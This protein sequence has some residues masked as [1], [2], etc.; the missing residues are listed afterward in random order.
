LASRWWPAL[1]ERP[2]F[3]PALHAGRRGQA[4]AEALLR[5]LAS[6]PTQPAI[7]RATALTLLPGVMTDASRASIEAALRDPQPLV[8]AG[9]LRALAAFPPQE[10][11]PLAAPLLDDD[12]RAVRQEAAR[13]LLGLPRQ[14]LGPRWGRLQ[15][16]LDELEAAERANASRPEN[17]LN[18][19]NH[20]LAR[21]RPAEAEAALRQALKLD[22]RSVAARV[23]LA[24]VLRATGRDEA[25]EAALREALALDPRAA[26]AHHALGLLLVRQGKKD[27]ALESLRA[28]VEHAPD[29]SRFAYVL[30]VALQDAG[31]HAEA[32]RVLAASYRRRPADLNV[33]FAL[34]ESVRDLGDLVTAR[35]YAAELA[36]RLPA[37][38]RVKQLVAELNR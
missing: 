24:D 37:D 16:V 22:P 10:R 6:E 3:A 2:S 32:A 7:A 12:L 23:N 25:S 35:N 14:A 26:A 1:S 21:G 18:L 11:A 17:Q 8:R 5:A 38:P 31:Q 33:L 4:N 29:A 27:A 19:A 36:Q 30:A 13:A 28:A 15:Q 9:A 34:V 20:L